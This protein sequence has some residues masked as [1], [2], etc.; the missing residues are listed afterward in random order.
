MRDGLI[1]QD[2]PIKVQRKASEELKIL[3]NK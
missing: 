2:N 3:Q 1:I